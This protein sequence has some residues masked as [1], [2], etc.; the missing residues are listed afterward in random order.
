MRPGDSHPWE[1]EPMSQDIN[2][3]IASSLFPTLPGVSLLA[4][5]AHLP[6]GLVSNGHCTEIAVSE[7]RALED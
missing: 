1:T 6:F 4:P 5:P 3:I 2:Q 7:G